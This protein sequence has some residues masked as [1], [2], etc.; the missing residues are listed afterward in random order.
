M[1]AQAPA[2]VALPAIER[3]LRRFMTCC[4]IVILL[5]MGRVARLA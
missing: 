5:W 3:N 2:T 1:L 4:G